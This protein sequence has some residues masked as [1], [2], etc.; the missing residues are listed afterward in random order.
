MMKKIIRGAMFYAD[1]DPIV[2]SE[3][4]GIRPVLIIQNDLGNK[5]SPTVL[6]APISTKKDKL[7]P[8]HILIKQFDK[9][10]HDSI[11][12][13]EQVR[14]LDKSRLK[15]YMGMLESDTLEKVNEAIKISFELK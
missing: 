10:R 6:V 4:K 15:G 2:G 14:V 5:H 12:M 7:L 13:L 3:Q 9:L 8:T 1:L 11:V